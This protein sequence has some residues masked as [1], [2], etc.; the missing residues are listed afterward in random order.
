MAVGQW[1]EE[2]VAQWLESNGWEILHRR[3]CCRWGEL[4]LVVRSPSVLVF[5]EVKTRGSGNWDADGLLSITPQKQAK[6][7]RAAELFCSTYPE[8]ADL[9]CR[10]D[11]ALVSHRPWS[12]SQPSAD[13]LAIGATIVLGQPI[14]FA[15][16]SWTLQT[17][18]ESAFDGC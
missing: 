7:W 8:L 4:D 16:R 14:V 11:V 15:D 1:G 6:L 18:L 13:L 2:I 10:F 12:R 17:Y 9:P 5:V 3:W